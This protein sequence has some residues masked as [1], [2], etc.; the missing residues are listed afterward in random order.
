MRGLGRFALSVFFRRIEVVGENNVP[1]EGPVIVVANHTNSLIDGVLVTGFLPRMP[2]LLAAST[3]WDERLLLPLL[4]AAGV[5]PVIRQQDSGKSQ[6]RNTDTFSKTWE[7][8]AAGGMLTL[9]PEGITHNEPF[10]M[11]VKTGAARIAL[12]AEEQCGPL[13]VTI[14]PVG[15]IFDDKSRFRSRC[16]MRIG[17]PIEFSDLLKS[18][19]AG[20]EA[21]RLN[22]VTEL[23]EKIRDA[24]TLATPHFDT[25]EEARLIGR[26][27]DIWGQPTPGLPSKRGLDETSKM[28][29]AFLNAYEWMRH[30]HPE[31]T[32]TFKSELAGYDRLLQAAGLRDEQVGATYPSASVLGFAGRS[33]LTLLI[34]L[35]LSILGT[36]LNILPILICNSI[37]QKYELERRGTWLLFPALGV[38]PAFW[39]LEALVIG[40]LSGFWLGLGW[41]LAIGAAFLVVGPITGRIALD[42]FDLS[43]R[44]SHEA[45][46]WTLLRTRKNVSERLSARRQAVL[47]ELTELVAIYRNETS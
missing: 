11:P 10:M 12:E 43:R 1:D 41:G 46:A 45:R 34:L 37:G 5:I 42:F 9:F 39:L 8:L 33:L 27:A 3:V 28:R 2:R 36:I 6:K 30:N 7:L 13:G 38:F 21:A 22:S 31:R 19:I 23:T 16:L 14:I 20:D 18:Y 26:A 4:D 29:Q 25:W 17:E 35:P 47:K 40:T 44:L 15:V 24:L 32:A